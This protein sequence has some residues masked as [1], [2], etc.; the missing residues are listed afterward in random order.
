MFR[1]VRLAELLAVIRVKLCAEL[2]KVAG[3]VLACYGAQ[4]RGIITM[5]LR[6]RS[7]PIVNSFRVMLM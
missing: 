3:H 6:E 7:L 1:I 4:T 5:G 2:L